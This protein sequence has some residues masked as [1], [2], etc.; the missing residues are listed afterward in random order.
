MSNMSVDSVEAPKGSDGS[1]NIRV[2]I[3]RTPELVSKDN[4]IAEL[5]QEV[6]KKDEIIKAYMV[7][8]KNRLQKEIQEEDVRKAELVNQG[9]PA[10]LGGETAPLEEI[11]YWKGDDYRVEPNDPIPRHISSDNIG[12]LYKYIDNMSKAGNREASAFL[13]QQAKRILRSGKVF[14]FQ[15]NLAKYERIGNQVVKANRKKTWKEVDDQ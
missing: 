7:S 8:E 15:G 12:D 11:D 2:L 1:R 10:P 14:E 5:E 13:G 3:D 6:G 4:K 9:K